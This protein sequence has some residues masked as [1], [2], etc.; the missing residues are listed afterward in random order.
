M[1]SFM[2]RVLTSLVCTSLGCSS[3][4]NPFRY[5]DPNNCA[6]DPG[7]CGA[8]FECNFNTEA[9]EPSAALPTLARPIWK[10]QA[11]LAAGD[12]AVGDALGFSLSLSAETALVG[13]QSAD[14]TGAASNDGAAYV[15]VRDPDRGTWTQQARLV[16]S[17]PAAGDLAGFAVSLFGDTALISAHMAD[18]SGVAQ[19]GAAYVFVR[20][21]S[22][23][24]WTQQ[25][26]LVAD[27]RLTGDL[28]GRAVAVSGDTALIGANQVDAGG[29][30][31]SGAAY[32]FLRNPATGVWA[33]QRPRLVPSDSA[34]G[35][36]F[37]VSVSVASDTAL[38]GAYLSG[39][40]GKAEAGAAYVFV[41]N[42]ASGSWVQQAKLLAD[43]GAGGDHFGL[44]VA[45]FGDIALVGAPDSDPGGKASAGAAYVFVR[46]PASGVW[47]QQAKLVSGDGVASDI[48]G[49][50]V[51]LSGNR[52]AITAR[53]ATSDGQATT[54]VAY[55]FAR[56][57]GQGTWVSEARLGAADAAPGD[58]SGF[59]VALSGDTLGLGA[60]GADIGGK[61]DVGAGYIFQYAKQNGDP[62]AS[63][64]ECHS[65]F[66]IDGVCCDSACG[67]SDPTDCQACSAAAGAILTPN[68]DG[69]C[70]PR[71]L[72]QLCRASTAA[73]DPPESCDAQL[74]SCPSDVRE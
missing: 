54:G 16:T 64:R 41:R 44:S 8:G 22:Q 4:W 62:C 3:L 46:N 28:F 55:V 17:D 61:T 71:R 39:S 12:G 69:I 11:K 51:A 47:T 73:A 25:A 24:T 10:Q 60:A 63:G 53:L 49:S 42:P 29:N 15:L 48:F 1:P 40:A 14:V 6:P 2:S 36:E 9:C 59:G 7:R 57:P 23:G 18:P 68:G 33:Q 20:N 27:D 70:R 45:L 21:P 58:S 19:A 43:D 5:P 30:S 67:G 13:A 35:D 38:V 65:T 52:A 72:G 74:L 66:C 32:V 50:A 26:K 56:A 31:S 37:G 34:S